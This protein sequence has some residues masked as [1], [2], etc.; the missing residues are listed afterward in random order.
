MVLPSLTSFN[1][2]T[3]FVPWYFLCQQQLQLCTV[4]P[5]GAFVW[6]TAV[7]YLDYIH[8]DEEMYGG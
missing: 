3:D 5:A 2:P 8:P 7:V 1:A 4:L 6:L